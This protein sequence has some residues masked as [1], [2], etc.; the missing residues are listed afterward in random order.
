MGEV[1]VFRGEQFHLYPG[2][3]C[4]RCGLLHSREEQ[5]DIVNDLAGLWL[6]HFLRDDQA[7][8]NA[9]SDSLQFSTRITGEHTCLTT[10]LI[11]APSELM[12]V[13][14]L[15][16]LDVLRLSGIEGSLA[17]RIHDLRGKLV[18]QTMTMDGTVD[19]LDLP[20]GAYVLEATSGRG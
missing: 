10:A 1:A 11:P 13:A 3:K 5:H 16:A 20:N 19:V 17:I 7:A 4:A 2:R 15:P 12:T 18:L 9:F 6:D 8:W 14:P